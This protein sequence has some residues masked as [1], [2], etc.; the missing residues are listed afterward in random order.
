MLVAGSTVLSIP[1]S[2]IRLAAVLS[3]CRHYHYSPAVP[4]QETLKG[5]HPPPTC[6]R[7]T[8]LKAVADQLVLDLTPDSKYHELVDKGVLRK[9][10]YQ[11][12]IVNKLQHLHDQIARYN[13]PSVPP[14]HSLQPRSFFSRLFSSS[15]SS[16]PLRSQLKGLYLYGTVGTGKTMLMD[17]FYDTLPPNSEKLGKRRVHFH[18]FMIDVHKR[19]HK[20]RMQHG[21]DGVEDVVAPV[22]RD[23]AEEARVLCFDEFQVTDIVDA[24]ILRR[25]LECL[26][27]HGVVSIMTSNGS[28]RH[29]DDLYKN[30]IQRQ[31]FLPCI[32]LIKERFDVTD[33]NS[34]TDYRKIPRALS[35]VYFDPANDE[36]RRQMNGIWDTLTAHTKVMHNEVMNVWGHKLRI[37]ESTGTGIARFSFEDLCGRPMGAADYLEI[38][39]RFHTLFIMDIPQMGLNQK[40][41]ARRFITLIDACYENKTRLFVLSEVPVP[42]IFSDDPISKDKRISDHMRSTMDDLG[43]SDDVVGSSAMFSGEEELFAFARACSRLIQMGTKEWAEAARG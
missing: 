36:N 12:H 24:M 37:P 18:A 15:S 7:I 21:W 26:L 27:Q 1:S 42:L 16:E 9:D 43:L 23:L 28:S 38:T 6:E 32:D 35:K 5:T 4:L 14:V 39:N 3:L 22:A 20:L 19:M 11:D 8:P 13:P 2:G 30:G 33:L 34:H 40:D 10:D 41:K 25:L 17:L 31:S 29:P